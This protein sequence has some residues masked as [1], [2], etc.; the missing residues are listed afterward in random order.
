MSETGNKGDEPITIDVVSDAVCPW[1]FVGKRNLETA[2]IAIGQAARAQRG[3][4]ASQPARRPSA[5]AA[6]IS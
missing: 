6:S 5:M 2:L 4:I 3:A 1:C